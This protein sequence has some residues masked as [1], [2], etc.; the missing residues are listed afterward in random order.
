MPRPASAPVRGSFF[1]GALLQSTS[2]S[3]T[4]QRSFTYNR[5]TAS[6][7]G[8]YTVDDG[9][10]FD[11]GL[12]VRAW[13]MLGFGASATRVA[14]SGTAHVEARYPHPFFFGRDRTA[15]LDLEGQDR[16]ELGMHVSAAIVPPAW[17]SVD[18][19]LFGGPSVFSVQQDVSG[20]LVVTDEYPYDSITLA[21]GAATR[22]KKT[23]VG[24]HAGGGITWYVTRH[25]GLGG[26]VR[27]AS[28]S[29]GV[30]IGSGS[31][32]D[33]KAGGVQAGLGLRVR[34]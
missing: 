32:F 12:F 29:T 20:D 27:Y 22:V 1:G 30:T 19:V 15:T 7:T 14:R 24:F 16:T 5:E 4:D 31:A 6:L 25:L 8:A 9:Y 11:A 23:V 18:V 26:L 2:Q 28:G 34:F 33:L 17:R 3:F 21:A 13:R 10:G